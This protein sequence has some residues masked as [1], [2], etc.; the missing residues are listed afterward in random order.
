[1]PALSM[2]VGMTR[3]SAAICGGTVDSTSR[4]TL[5]S[6]AAETRGIIRFF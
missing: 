1:L 2:S 5:A 6:A 4:G 3:S